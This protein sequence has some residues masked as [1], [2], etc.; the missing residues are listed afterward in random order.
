MIGGTGD[1]QVKHKNHSDWIP[2]KLK[3]D[4]YNADVIKTKTESRCEVKLLE[5]SVVRIGEKS[6]FEFSDASVAKKSKKV[7]AQLKRGKVWS[8]IV[9]MKNK[10]EVK[11]PED[12]VR[13]LKLMRRIMAYM[14]LGLFVFIFVEYGCTKIP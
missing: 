6:E 5:G 3:M 8:N 10:Q 4:I 14:I 12:V 2:A 9:K 13:R 11:T 7:N 1:V